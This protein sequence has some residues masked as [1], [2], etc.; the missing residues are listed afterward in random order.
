MEGCDWDSVEGSLLQGV[1]KGSGYDRD[2][3]QY[4]FGGGWWGSFIYNLYIYDNS[5]KILWN[6]IFRI[7]QNSAYFYGISDKTTEVNIP[8]K[9]HGNIGRESARGGDYVQNFE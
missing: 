9:Y 1:I 4:F 6:S 3:L 2:G 5:T 7:S 8:A